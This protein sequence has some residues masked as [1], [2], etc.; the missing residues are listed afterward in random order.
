MKKNQFPPTQGFSLLEVLIAAVIVTLAASWAIPQYRRQ[1]ALNQLDQY[2]QKIESGLFS[3]RARQSTE[4]T[5]C[6]IKFA[7]NYVGTDNINGDFGSVENIV[8]L[9]HLSKEDRAQR[10][11]CCDT[12]Q[13]EWNPPYRLI[14]LEQTAISKNVEIKVSQSTY[15]LSPPGTST[16]GNAL[17]MLVRSTSWDQDPQRPLPIRCIKFSTSG[18]LH[19]GTWED[20]RCRRR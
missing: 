8:E 6:E 12:K 15:S 2:T 11:Q 14:D 13:C 4:G 5:S 10:L 19:S 1:L 17:V 18:H 7:A 3:L 9:G 16:D 20:T